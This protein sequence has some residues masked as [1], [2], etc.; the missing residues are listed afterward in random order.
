MAL[1]RDDIAARVHVIIKDHIA[2][3]GLEP[4][5]VTDASRVADLDLDSLDRI[6]IVMTAEDEFDLEIGD[7]EIERLDTVGGFIDH[8]ATRLGLAEVAA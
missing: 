2:Q 1:T 6:E 8:V 3:H 7:D 4:K 5:V